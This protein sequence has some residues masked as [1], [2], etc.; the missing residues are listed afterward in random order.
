MPPEEQKSELLKLTKQHNDLDNMLEGATVKTIFI[1]QERKRLRDLF[2]EFGNITSGASSL[3]PPPLNQDGSRNHFQH[4]VE[5]RQE[6]KNS[7]MRL[8]EC[9]YQRYILHEPSKLALPRPGKD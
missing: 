4:K 1:H 8:K 9:R 3:Q 5:T 2:F 7:L 6:L